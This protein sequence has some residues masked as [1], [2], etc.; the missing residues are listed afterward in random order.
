MDRIRGIFHRK[1]LNQFAVLLFVLLWSHSVN[2]AF[3]EEFRDS[4][5]S[6]ETVSDAQIP[7]DSRH[8][9]LSYNRITR[10]F[11]GDFASLTQ[12]QNL[13]LVH[14]QVNTI[15]KKLLKPFHVSG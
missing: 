10:L 4:S 1:H 7:P 8:V 3:S 11:D 5:G 12:L 13:Y 2:V 9:D 6:L 15:G 14:N